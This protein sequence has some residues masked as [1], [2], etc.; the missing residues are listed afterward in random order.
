[1]WSWV[2]ARFRPPAGRAAHA[3]GAEERPSRTEAGQRPTAGGSEA[4]ARGGGR[5][6]PGVP[7]GGALALALVIA[8]LAP[9]PL[10]AQPLGLGRPATEAEIAA[11]D[12]DVRPDGQGLP[13][14]QG[15]VAEGE[16]LFNEV[17]AA[18]HGDFGEGL[19]LYPALAGGEGSLTVSQGRPTKSIGSFDP[20]LST[21]FDFIHR[22]K[23]F[24]DAQSYSDD[25]VYA[26]V[27]YLLYLNDLVDE[28]FT[29]S[30]EN[31][32]TIHLPNEDG[33]FDDDRQVAEIPRFSEPPCMTDCRNKVA[34]TSRALP[35]V[36]PEN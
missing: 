20:Y 29:L 12:I 28:T 16:T 3:G 9:L 32:T 26:L 30:R 13:P 11:W 22:A 4:P 33:F 2:S 14:G 18:C 35:D 19:G 21:I 17:C 15:S 7:P 25:E 6:L 34:I 8:F 10:A 31:F 1:M 5:A 23:P 27:A 36:T 24:G